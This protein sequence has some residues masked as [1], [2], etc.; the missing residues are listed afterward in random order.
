M[1][2]FPFPW[3]FICRLCVC[4][5]LFPHSELAA[6]V[7]LLAFVNRKQKHT[8]NVNIHTQTQCRT[9]MVWSSLG[10]YYF[11]NTQCG[12]L[13]YCLLN[14]AIGTA[15]NDRMRSRPKRFSTSSHQ[16]GKMGKLMVLPKPKAHNLGNW[17]KSRSACNVWHLTQSSNYFRRNSWPPQL[18]PTLSK[19]IHIHT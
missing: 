2:V 15:P 8:V 9:I 12:Y 19:N 5:T 18:R 4:C 16:T 13:L 1:Y 7:L 17:R 6:L 3:Q 11:Q 14:D 10:T